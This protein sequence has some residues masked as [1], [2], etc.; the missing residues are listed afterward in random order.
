MRGQ[1]HSRRYLCVK[2]VYSLFLDENRSSKILKEYQDDYMF[3][4]ITEEVERDPAAGG[5]AKRRVEGGGGDA[6]PMEH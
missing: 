4:E 2:K 1:P 6:Q 5:G 3:S